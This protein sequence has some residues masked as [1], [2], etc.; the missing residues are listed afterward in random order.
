MQYTS[1]DKLTVVA[2]ENGTDT[3]SFDALARVIIER[4][5]NIIYFEKE[6][7][8][9]GMI[10]MGDI[11]RA[12][13]KGIAYVSVNKNFTRVLPGEYMLARKLFYKKVNINAIPVVSENNILLG[14]YERWDDLN[15]EHMLIGGQNIP[16]CHG[17]VFLVRPCSIFNEK[18][19]VFTRFHEYLSSVGVDVQELEHNEV[20][21]YVDMAEWILFTDEDEWRAMDTLIKRI[22]HRD[23]LRGKLRTYKSFVQEVRY[24]VVGEYLND[25]KMREVYV[26]NLVCRWNSY[27]S[28]LDKFFC[29]R[30]AEVNNKMG[31]TIYKDFFCDLYTPEYAESIMHLPFSIET[32][33][34]R[35]KL[36]DCLGEFYNV[37]NGERYTVGQMEEYQRTIWFVGPCL[38]YGHFVED[39]NTIESL[40]QKRLRDVGQKIRVVNCG[41]Q[42]L[43]Q[44]ELELARIKELPLKRGD[45]LILYADDRSFHGIV[46]LNIFDILQKYN[47]YAGWMMDSA[48]HSNH[49]LNALYAEAIYDVLKPV[50]ETNVEQGERIMQDDDFVK[51]IYINRYFTGFNYKRYEKI[52]A[53]VMN[54]NP[55]TYGH[56]Y[57]IEQALMM[58]DFLI[59]FVVQ[60]DKSLF[61]FGE[62]FAMVCESVKDLK[63]VMAVPSGPYILSKT[64]F[65]EYFI[66]EADEDIVQNA[67]NDITFFAEQIAPHL[68]IRYRFVG[69]EPEDMVTNEYNLAMKRILPKYDIELIEV[70][71]KEQ[72]G[73]CISASLVRE[74]LENNDID[75][76]KTLVPE[77]ARKILFGENK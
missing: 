70:P 63:C 44:P 20:A 7:K 46:E 37:I 48:L 27:C 68:N 26:L 2:L 35:G 77:S 54:C 73:K 69:E 17:K 62:R 22:L 65:P 74:C 45:I 14:A 23:F 47:V 72:G 8:I 12:D 53:I 36:K 41:S 40:L 39:R 67:E 51:T 59:I 33:S 3:I 66:K 25:I 42:Y 18:T 56:R 29:D 64:T 13:K 4:P 16:C 57:L 19:R 32:K 11:S 38:I 24:R 10:S 71:R 9:Y 6:G 5:S 15:I 61:S 28:V 58:I 31:Q 60:E 76:L 49:K 34:H 75:Q 21:Y 52:G 30:P 43:E 50:I 1:R 55:F